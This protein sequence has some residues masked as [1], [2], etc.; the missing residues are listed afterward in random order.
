M[1]DRLIERASKAR[2]RGRLSRALS[3]VFPEV[4]D[5]VDH[6]AL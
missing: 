4:F 3:E 2:L 6:G 5:I 1:G